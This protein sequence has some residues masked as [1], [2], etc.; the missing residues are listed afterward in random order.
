MSIAGRNVRR[1]RKSDLIAAR[2]PETVRR[3]PGELQGAPGPRVEPAQAI[4]RE[5]L[6]R[7]D[8]VGGVQEDHVDGEAQEKGVDGAARIDQQAVAVAPVGPPE[9]PLEPRPERAGDLDARRDRPRGIAGRRGQEVITRIRGPTPTR[10]G[11]A[12]W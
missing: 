4:A 5:P 11:A 9:Q 7:D 1:R 8:P 6:D 10:T 2:E 3:A 12:L